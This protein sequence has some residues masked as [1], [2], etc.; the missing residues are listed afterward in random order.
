MNLVLVF[1]VTLLGS[2]LTFF[3]GFGLGTILLP[4]FLV[5]FA[6]ELAI[7][8]VALVHFSNSIFKFVYVYKY[9][10]FPILFRFGIPAVLAAFL[11]A[12]LLK[13]FGELPEIYS[14]S[15]QEHTFHVSG[16]NFMIGCLIILFTWFET[17]KISAK[18]TFK[19]N[20]LILGGLLS[21]FF[22][23]LSGHQGALRSLFLNQVGLVKEEFIGTS[24]AISL[25]IDLVRISIYLQ[26]ISLTSLFA[27]E[28][29]YFII[30]GI[31]GAFIGTSLGNRLLKKVTIGFVHQLISIF[32]ILF[33][34][35]LMLGII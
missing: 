19:K 2:S 34:L 18:L 16:I 23:G 6:P 25:A 27:G 8:A 31:A 7:P 26:M 24:N 9:I 35:L 10:H 1:L 3:S 14:Y 20:R 22:G 32:L 11:G 13:L 30:F 15:I 4:L 5:F 21:G 29:K 17:S 12:E 33:G 28:Q